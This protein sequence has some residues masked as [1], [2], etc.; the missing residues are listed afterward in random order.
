MDKNLEM[1]GKGAVSYANKSLFNFTLSY[2]KPVKHNLY[3]ISIFIH[4]ISALN[5]KSGTTQW[6]MH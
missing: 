3:K 6:K 4:N 5:D 2:F 1:D